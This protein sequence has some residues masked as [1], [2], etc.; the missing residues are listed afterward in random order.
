MGKL[1]ARKL[2]KAAK[3]L[4]QTAK[5]TLAYYA[6]FGQLWG[7]ICPNDPLQ[8]ITREIRRRTRAA[9]AFPDGEPDLNL[10]AAGS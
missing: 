3:W 6:F 5:E 1:Q 2:R 9:G 4:E 8:R 10:A 7:G